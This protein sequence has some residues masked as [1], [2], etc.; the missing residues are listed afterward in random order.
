MLSTPIVSDQGSSLQKELE[1]CFMPSTLTIVS[2]QGSSLQKELETC[3]M[4]STLTR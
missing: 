4:P 3:F 2:D 1:T